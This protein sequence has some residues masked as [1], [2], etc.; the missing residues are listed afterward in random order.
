MKFCELPKLILLLVCETITF[1]TCHTQKLKENVQVSLT[2]I[3][4]NQPIQGC[5]IYHYRILLVY[6][7]SDTSKEQAE[8]GI[9]FCTKFSV[10]FQ[11]L[12]FLGLVMT[13]SQS[14]SQSHTLF[15]KFHVF[16]PSMASQDLI[17]LWG[18]AQSVRIHFGALNC[19]LTLKFCVFIVQVTKIR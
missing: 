2:N 13:L 12:A 5:F 4:Y 19:C 15:A 3:Y 7:K 16:N 18:G 10:F 8:Q 14:V 6:Y 9:S 11:R 17:D 1:Q